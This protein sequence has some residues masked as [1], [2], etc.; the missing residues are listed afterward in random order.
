MRAASEEFYHDVRA[1]R[2]VERAYIAYNLPQ[3]LDSVS[4][5]CG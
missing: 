1:L 3:R 2:V 5:H 4:E